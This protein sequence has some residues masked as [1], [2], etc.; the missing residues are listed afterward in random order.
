[1]RDYGDRVVIPAVKTVSVSNYT[2]TQFDEAQTLRSNSGAEEHVGKI[3]STLTPDEK[4]QYEYEKGIL[5][6]TVT[7]DKYQTA[8]SPF[9]KSRR[10]TTHTYSWVYRVLKMR[11]AV[12]AS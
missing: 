3:Y 2:R 10:R 5:P 1:M 11:Y 4:I 7:F 9:K 6:T 12:K 8:T